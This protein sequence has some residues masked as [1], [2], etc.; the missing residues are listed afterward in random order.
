MP[1]SISRP[2][3]LYPIGTYI[4]PIDN[5]NATNTSWMEWTATVGADWPIDPAILLFK[6]V[7]AWNSGGGQTWM[8]YGGRTGKDGALLT[9]LR[10]STAV[11]Q[12][13]GTGGLPQ[14]R[15]VVSGTMTIDVFRPI[16]SVVT[17]QAIA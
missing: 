12:E 2:S 1:R 3:Q 8:I 5:F 11:P 7:L 6:V 15:T 17:L 16:T 14:K 13:A 9:I 4:V 10:N